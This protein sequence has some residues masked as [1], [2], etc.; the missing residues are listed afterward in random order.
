MKKIFLDANIII[1][2]L[3]ASSKDHAI[4]VSC[5]RIIRK[6]FGKAFSLTRNIRY[7]KFFLGKFVKNKEWH[8]KQMQLVFSGMAITPIEPSFIS[9]IFKTK[10]EDLEDGLQY[11]CAFHAKANVIITKD[12]HDYFDSKIP[13]VHP[14][15]FVMR[16]N[17]LFQI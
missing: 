14:H 5:F 16:Y 2:Y 7:R 11:Q 17:S 3:D 10:F 9:A 6:N 12:L 1:D 13:A 4:A 15:D 8:K